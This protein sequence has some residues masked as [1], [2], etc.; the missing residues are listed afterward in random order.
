MT[1]RLAYLYPEIALFIATCFVMVLGLSPVK[2]SRK[3]VPGVAGLGVLIATLLAA[4]TTP[5]GDRVVA[6]GG[7]TLLPNLVPYAKVMIGGVGFLLLLLLGGTV[8]RGDEE[9]IASGKAKFD[10][11]RSNRAEFY[12]FY[13]F[14]L[15]G[16]MLCASADDLIWLFLALELTSLPTYI[17]VSISTADNRGREA[18]VKYFFLGALGAAIFLY[19]FALLYGATGSTNF[20]EIHAAFMQGGVTSLGLAGLMISILGVAFKIA[21]VPMHFY[22]AD[23]YQGAAAQVSAFLAFVPKTAGFLAMLLLLAC[24]GWGYAP[25]GSS[26]GEADIYGRGSDLPELVRLLLWVM[27]AMTMTVGNVLALLQTSVKRILAYSSVA[28]SGYMLVGLIAGP[29]DGSFTQN[30]LAAVLFY[31]LCYGTMNIGTFAVLA[32]VEHKANADGEH[33]GIDSVADLRGLSSKSPALGWTMTICALS[34]LGLPPLLGFFGKIPLFT[35]AIS[36]GEI[37][38]VVVLGLNSAIAAFYYL[39]LAFAP[40]LEPADTTAEPSFV[41]PLRARVIGGVL[42]AVAVIVL[43][44]LGNTLMAHSGKAGD[45][46][47]GDAKAEV[48]KPATSQTADASVLVR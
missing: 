28:H 6:E 26:L 10:P 20:N 22:T 8:D 29:G 7:Q 41:T 32:A 5:W 43:S 46:R 31:L 48:T 9:R 25:G 17:M 11:L 47:P 2:E 35:S 34:L 4:F 21:A 33:R 42:S 23:V 1:E 19:G 24:V 38:L 3:L 12:S 27:A 15:T 39:K 37:P 30:G 13:L 36:A 44:V 14:S 16:L 40:F 18:G 45:Y